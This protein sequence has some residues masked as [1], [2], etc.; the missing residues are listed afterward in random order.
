MYISMDTLSSD[1]HLTNLADTPWTSKGSDLAKDTGTLDLL[2][3]E[4]AI[5]LSRRI[6]AT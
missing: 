5:R 4:H 2:H 3:P 1:S 6:R